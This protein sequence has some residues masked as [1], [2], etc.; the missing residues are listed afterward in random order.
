MLMANLLE[1]AQTEADISDAELADKLDVRLVTILKWKRGQATPKVPNLMKV[2][3][4]LNLP[5][6]YFDEWINMDKNEYTHITTPDVACPF[7]SYSS[8][9]KI[10]CEGADY[11]KTLK[12]IIAGKVS[13]TFVSPA[14]L[15]GHMEQFCRSVSGCEDCPYYKMAYAKYEE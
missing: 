2:I 14:H 10:N 4:A 11:K 15:V 3:K 12:G 9:N 6:D 13:I 8:A 1:R 5:E 7:Y